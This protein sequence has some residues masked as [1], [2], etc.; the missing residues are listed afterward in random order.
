MKIRITL[1]VLLAAATFAVPVAAAPLGARFST[2][3]EYHGFTLRA[4]RAATAQ[5]EH[6]D[7]RIGR[8]AWADRRHASCRVS[9]RPSPHLSIG[10]IDLITRRGRCI[11][12]GVNMGRH[13]FT[14]PLTIQTID[15][16]EWYRR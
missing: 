14:G 1:I 13:C 8:C 11:T 5:F 3:L 2:S 9:Q 10:W 16:Q 12:H 15:R 6:G 7:A 4:A